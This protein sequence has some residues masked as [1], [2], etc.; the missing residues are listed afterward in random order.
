[1]V[2]AIDI[3]NTQTHIGFYRNGKFEKILN[4]PTEKSGKEKVLKKIFLGNNFVAIAIASVVPQ[5]TEG[6]IKFFKKFLHTMPLI[7]S[8]K[9][10]TPVKFR[11]RNIN[12]LGA[13][14]IANVVGANLRYKKDLIIFSF[15]TATVCDVVLKNGKYLGGLIAPGIKTGIR[16][17]ES[18]TTLLKKV[19]LKIPKKF[20][21]LSTEE[22][23]QSGILNGTRL[24]V[25]GVIREI[26]GQYR[27]KFFCVST[28]GLGKLMK[29][30]IPEI[31]LYDPELTLYGIIKIYYL[32]V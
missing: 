7:V 8:G 13:D 1:M 11:Y 29:D 24:M 4:L 16:A 3:G 17:L 10:K 27:K 2:V 28:G 9:L 26:E 14:R 21:G 20:L 12:N 31:S 15:G 23:L 30:L 19:P 18:R 25:Q 32:N 22:C 5:V 6:Y